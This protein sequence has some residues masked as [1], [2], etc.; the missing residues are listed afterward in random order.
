MNVLSAFRFMIP[1]C[2][3]IESS[4]F[5]ESESIGMGIV[6]GGAILLGSLFAMSRIESKAGV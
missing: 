5:L 1:L 6:V 4:V 2:G 3:V